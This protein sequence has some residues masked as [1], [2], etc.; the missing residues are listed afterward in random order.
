[1]EFASR[2]GNIN[3]AAGAALIVFYAFHDARGFAA[4]GAIGALGRVHLFFAICCLGN[5][6]H[7]LLE[8]S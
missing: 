5:L 1:M 3:P 6:G 8:F 4:L 2:A 7:G